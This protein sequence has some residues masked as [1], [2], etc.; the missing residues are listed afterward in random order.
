MRHIDADKF[1]EFLKDICLQ[2]GWQEDDKVFSI[3]GLNSAIS[4]I[5][6]MRRRELLEKLKKEVEE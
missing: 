2:R 5:Y 4:D 1:L 3:K 6:D